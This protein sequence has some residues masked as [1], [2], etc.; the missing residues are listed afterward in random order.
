MQVGAANGTRRHLDDGV[1]R[2]LDLRISHALTPYIALAVLSQRFHCLVTF[3]PAD[4]IVEAETGYLRNNAARPPRFMA[5]DNKLTVFCRATIKTGTTRMPV[6][7]SRA[8][9]VR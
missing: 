1:L 4:P 2:V 9:K 5:V 8:I 3:E 7:A 6:T